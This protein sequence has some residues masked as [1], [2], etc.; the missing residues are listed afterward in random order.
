MV[1]VGASPLIKTVAAAIRG[2]DANAVSHVSFADTPDQ[3]RAILFAQH[4]HYSEQRA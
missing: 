3:A 2:L 4:Y 1:V